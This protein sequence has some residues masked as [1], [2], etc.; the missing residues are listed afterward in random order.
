MMTSCLKA[1]T[2]NTF[3]WPGRCGCPG[4]FGIPTMTTCCSRER[5]F[6]FDGLVVDLS[7]WFEDLHAAAYRAI[8][9]GAGFGIDQAR[10][11]IEI[12][13]FIREKS[14]DDK[15]LREILNRR[16]PLDPWQK[17]RVLL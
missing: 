3:L 12:V 7:A 11:S 6:D 15:L 5:L 4:L 16:A 9:G 1:A 2:G 8:L 13:E 17:K 10:Q 14:G